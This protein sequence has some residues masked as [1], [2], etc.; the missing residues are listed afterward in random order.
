[1]KKLIVLGSLLIITM[2]AF[3]ACSDVTVQATWISP[4]VASDS[5]SITASA[6]ES[7][8]IV[9]FRVNTSEGNTAF[10]AYKIGNTTYAR[11]NYCPP[12]R[13]EGFS[14]QGSTL[15]CDSCGS[16]FNAI[17][18]AGIQGACVDYPKASVPYTTNGGNLVMTKANLATA[19]IAT[20]TIY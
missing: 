6:I 11:A 3:V 8:K 14:L 16:T 10:M 4:Q 9:H 17:T 18:G 5:A 13:S 15:V 2:L 1:M 19:H 20:Q 7:N 12:C